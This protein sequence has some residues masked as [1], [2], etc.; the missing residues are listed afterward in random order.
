MRR[1][2]LGRKGYNEREERSNRADDEEFYRPYLLSMQGKDDPLAPAT[3]GSISAICKDLISG[4][5]GETDSLEVLHHLEYNGPD[6]IALF[7]PIFLD[8]ISTDSFSP[9]TPEDGNDPLAHSSSAGRPQR[10][11][12]VE[13]RWLPRRCPESKEA[14]APTN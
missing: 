6:Q 3:G 1:Y 4:R 9:A 8:K 14:L 11:L 10:R 13:R 7:P 2:L 5:N 12:S